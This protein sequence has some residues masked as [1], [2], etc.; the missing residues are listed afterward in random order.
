M[1]QQK[2]KACIA[3]LIAIALQVVATELIDDDHHDE[4]GMAIV[5]GG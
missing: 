5:G 4:F 1:V 3:E 2:A